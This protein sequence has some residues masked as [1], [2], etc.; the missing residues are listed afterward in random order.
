MY[1][2]QTASGRASRNMKIPPNYGGSAF[3]R[4]SDDEFSAAPITQIEETTEEQEQTSDGIAAVSMTSAHDSE[5]E[6]AG[7]FHLF[8]SGSGG[9]GLEELLILG[10]VLLISQN[11]VKDD[12]AFL[13]LLLVFIK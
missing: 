8:G 6:K 4:E 12:L 7:L 9:I 1:A 3:F 13:L 5:D 10:L 2:R 11:D